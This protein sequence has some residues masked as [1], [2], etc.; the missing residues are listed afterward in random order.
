M[1]LSPLVLF[2][3]YPAMLQEVPPPTATQLASLPVTLSSLLGPI[4]SHSSLRLSALLTHPHNPSTSA[5]PLELRFR[6]PAELGPGL[7]QYMRERMYSLV[8]PEG[9][10]LT[11]LGT[12]SG[13]KGSVSAVGDEAARGQIEEVLKAMRC[14][15]D[16]PEADARE[17]W[18]EVLLLISCRNLID[19]GLE[20]ELECADITGT[21]RKDC[22]NL[23]RPTESG[24]TSLY[25][26]QRQALWFMRERE[27]VP[28][29]REQSSNLWRREGSKSWR[30][31]IG[32]E[33]RQD[34]PEECRGGIVADD[35]GLGKTIQVLSLVCCDLDF[36]D[37]LSGE[38]SM[39][40]T[41]NPTPGAPPNPID[42]DAA[43]PL[44]A[45]NE[46]LKPDHYTLMHLGRTTSYQPL[47]PYGRS[48]S[49]PPSVPPPT[50]TTRATLIVC[51]LS[52]VANWEEQVGQHLKP[53]VRVA[54]HHG[55]GRARAAETL[56]ENDVVLTTYD[57]LAIE[58][59]KLAKA[60]A[61]A[62][63]VTGNV[64]V[65]ALAPLH[66]MRWRRVVLD[67]A[68]VIKDFTRSRAKACSELAAERRWCITGT[69]ILNRLDDLYS[70]VRFLRLDPFSSRATWTSSI[71]RP[72]K[73]GDPIGIT[74]LQT[75][76]KLVTLR[77]TKTQTVAG[78]PI[79]DLVPRDVE[80][81]RMIMVGEE[82]DT[83]ER[84]AK[85]AHKI[86][87]G[88][89]QAG[90]VMS[91]Y[92]HVLEM[93]LRLRQL[94]THPG[95]CKKK[96]LEFQ[97]IIDQYSDVIDLSDDSAMSKD[98][99]V[100]ALQVLRDADQDQCG[101]CGM[102]VEGVGNDRDG[103]DKE[104]SK[105]P[106]VTRC[107]H[108]YCKTCVDEK[109]ERSSMFQCTLCNKFAGKDDVLEIS[110]DDCVKG[111]SI[112]GSTPDPFL[113]GLPVWDAPSGTPVVKS[114][115]DVVWDFSRRSTKIAALL[116]DL[117]SIIAEGHAHGEAPE[118]SVV[119]SQWTTFLDVIAVHLRN[120]GIRFVRLDGK[121][122][123]PER[124]AAMERFKAEPDVLVMLVSLKAGGV[125]LNLTVAS[126][127][128]LMEPYWNRA[129]EN[130]AI[131][132]IHRLGQK[133]RVKIVRYVIKDSI[134]EN[135]LKLQEKKQEL[136]NMA[137]TAREDQEEDDGDRSQKKRGRGGEGTSRQ[138]KQQK[139]FAELQ[140]LF[141]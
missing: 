33:W 125:G 64:E 119:F 38:V 108:L 6:G 49:P 118:K 21:I 42:L 1:P 128:F 77:R 5:A 92:V 35:M 57:V 26:H 70:L 137:L 100:E 93:T 23:L 3:F 80:V 121:M 15:A 135:I 29:L 87:S 106:V 99:A 123:R 13:N 91:H 24:R 112:T 68:H 7:A 48:S 114:S 8:P 78:K 96:Q 12:I 19:G 31:V 58:Y 117:T 98:K 67:E 131:D 103:G 11:V 82:R 39:T 88:L 65:T 30:N 41:S 129:V 17:L 74:R 20:F 115:E 32:G 18:I 50:V 61:G 126:R 120:E 55:A 110:D 101:F 44:S 54:V 51:P 83:Y 36:P 27:K 84:A 56:G 81:R 94:A 37:D 34:N 10:G 141:S 52:T 85:I 116:Q 122:P 75:L 89:V 4:L 63:S 130:Q 102:T 140:S 113:S 86:F 76:M 97:G 72:L 134:E 79:L 22:D 2:G 66:A 107:G 14:A 138:Q 133:R 62:G 43:H 124:N 127:A 16:L 111:Q 25:P 9:S 47:A 109:L 90:T 139:R 104:G 132:R 46:P 60:I 45:F 69:P 28:A 95:L 73:S 53:G 59:N 105:V 136:V 71:A 40:A